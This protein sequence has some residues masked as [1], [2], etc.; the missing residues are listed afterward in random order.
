MTAFIIGN[1]AL[2]LA[3]IF[4]LGGLGDDKFARRCRDIWKI[5]GIV[6]CICFIIWAI[7]Y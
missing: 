6:A 7:T 3:T 2:I 1:I 4:W 5:L